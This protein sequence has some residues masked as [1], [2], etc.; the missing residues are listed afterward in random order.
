MLQ[1]IGEGDDESQLYG[2]NGNFLSDIES[3][4]MMDHPPSRRGLWF[5]DGF[6]RPKSN[7]AQSHLHLPLHFRSEK[8]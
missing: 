2:N 6:F 5:N 4:Y 3:N 1:D 8:S 7:F